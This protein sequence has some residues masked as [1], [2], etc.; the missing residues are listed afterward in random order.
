MTLRR[1][2]LWSSVLVL[3]LAF[4]QLLA[5]LGFSYAL[6][7][8]LPGYIYRKQPLVLERGQIVLACIPASHVPLAIARGYFRALSN[9]SPCA[10]NEHRVGKL[11]LALPGDQVDL[12]PEGLRVNGSLLPSTAP[13]DFDSENRPLPWLSSYRSTVPPDHVWIGSI[14][15][16]SYDSRYFGAIPTSWLR[17]S[18]RRIF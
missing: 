2:A 15:P 7:R 8:S 3:A 5:A 11:L 17:A 9:G 16:L 10:S 1:T 13:R 18:L 12:S 6:S 4:W 14:H